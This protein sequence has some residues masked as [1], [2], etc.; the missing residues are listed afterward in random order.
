MDTLITLPFIV[1]P[2]RTRK[3][4]NVKCICSQPGS[5]A[6]VEIHV[7]EAR[8]RVKSQLGE[9]TFKNCGLDAM[10]EQVLKLWTA[11]DKK[12]LDN[13]EKLIPHNKHENFIKIASN[14]FGSERTVDLAKYYY[15]VFLPR[16]L[17][18]LTRAEATNAV[19]VNT[20][21]E[22]NDQDDDNNEQCSEKKSSKSRSSSKRYHYMILLKDFSSCNICLSI[23][24]YHLCKKN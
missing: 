1:E 20:D 9:K 2:R 18:S 7:K 3:A 17:A 12:K 21:D 19:D 24:L 6:C 11:A 23:I 16:R 8:S 13:I 5:E 22:G 10:G 15:N 14:Q 4:V